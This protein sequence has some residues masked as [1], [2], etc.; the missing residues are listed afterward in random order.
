MAEVRTTQFGLEILGDFSKVRST[1]FG[2]EV[3]WTS[4]EPEDPVPNVEENS[5]VPA[6]T[7]TG[8]G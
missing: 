1:Q 6:A 2:L 3:L 4:V 5:F 7:L 8:V